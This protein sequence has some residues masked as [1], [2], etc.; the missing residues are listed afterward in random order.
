MPEK[1]LKKGTN[2]KIAGV[3]SGFAEYFNIDVTFVRIIWLTIAL[4]TGVGFI[5]YLIAALVMEE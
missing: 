1:R 5:A 4:T 2:K 3:C